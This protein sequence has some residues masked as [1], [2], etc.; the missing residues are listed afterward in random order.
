M[1]NYLNPRP[2]FSLKETEG[3]ACHLCGL[4]A[5]V[6]V[7]PLPSERDQNFFVSARDGKRYI[8]K[9][10]AAGEILAAYHEDFLLTE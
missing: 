3:L 8:L 7:E 10:A 1:S 2:T 4:E 9:I 5:E 6:G